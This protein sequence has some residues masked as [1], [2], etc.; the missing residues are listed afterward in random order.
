MKLQAAR[1]KAATTQQQE[2]HNEDVYHFENVKIINFFFCLVSSFFSSIFT[3]SFL[4][5]LLLY[6][7]C[8]M[9]LLT[10]WLKIL[11]RLKTIVCSFLY[12]WNR[13]NQ[14]SNKSQHKVHFNVCKWC[15][16]AIWRLFGVLIF[17]FN[18]NKTKQISKR[19]F[20]NTLMASAANY[21]R[22]LYGWKRSKH[23][24]FQTHF[25]FFGQLKYVDNKMPDHL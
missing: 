17:H 13:N 10:V 21:F 22:Q 11:S 12:N 14:N 16:C 24:S 9:C 6:S 2:K 23:L 19:L 3:N 4:A 5:V 20:N 8:W 18:A 25:L 15:G 7:I 1:N